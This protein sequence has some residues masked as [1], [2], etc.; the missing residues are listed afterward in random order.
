VVIKD[1]N[2]ARTNDLLLEV[3]MMQQDRLPCLKE[4]AAGVQSQI[5]ERFQKLLPSLSEH[6]GTDLVKVFR[7]PLSRFDLVC[8]EGDSSALATYGALVDELERRHGAKRGAN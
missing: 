6:F 8:R 1:V 3:G 7:S 5:D 4:A 2:S